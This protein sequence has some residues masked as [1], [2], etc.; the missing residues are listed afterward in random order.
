[1]AERRCLFVAAF[2]IVAL[3]ACSDAFGPLDGTRTYVLRTVDGAA[4]PL[5]GR[6]VPV[7]GQVILSAQGRFERR[8][9]YRVDTTGTLKEEVRAGIYQL[10]GYV[11]D[12][13]YV[14]R[15]WSPL[16]ELTG[17]TLVLRM[18]RVDDGYTIEIYE[19]Q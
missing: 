10:R 12:V 11:L 15:H 9:R 6:Y 5:S 18:P 14:G 2:C 16:G 3:G 8:Y 19:R 1:M 7:D 4:V 17:R 13:A